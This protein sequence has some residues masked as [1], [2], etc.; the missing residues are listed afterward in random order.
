L[1]ASRTCASV[2]FLRGGADLVGLGQHDLKG[3]GGAVQQR[4]DLVIDRLHPV[5]H[6]DQHEGPAQRRA[7]GEIRLEE[8]LPAR[9]HGLR[10]LGETVAGQVHEIGPPAEVE[11]VDLLRTAG[12]VRGPRQRLATGKRVD[13]GRLADVRAAG[14]ADLQPVGRRQP[15]HR[16]DALDELDRPG[17]E[18]APGLLGCRVGRLGQ[19]EGQGGH[20]STRT[21]SPRAIS[22]GCVT[23]A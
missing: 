12:R 15:V 16:D 10:R 5:A 2:F 23:C 8:R 22:P 14:E 20:A 13:Q 4:H 6:V 1:S 18:L 11:E 7:A 19:R 3:D 21:A 9:H 17:K